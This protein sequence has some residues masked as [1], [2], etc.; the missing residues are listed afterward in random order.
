MLRRAHTITPPN[1]ASDIL[2]NATNSAI[3]P[4]GGDVG[5]SGAVTAAGGES[6]GMMQDLERRLGKANLIR[7]VPPPVSGRETLRRP[8]FSQI[9]HPLFTSP[10]PHLCKKIAAALTHSNPAAT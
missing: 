4:G 8:C 6:G 7:R 2:A 10:V 1:P 9:L 5:N 3:R